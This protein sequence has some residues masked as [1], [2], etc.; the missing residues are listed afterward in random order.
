MKIMVESEY[1]KAE[2]N[3][4]LLLTQR[5]IQVCRLKCPTG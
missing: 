4:K 2:N 5:I 3:E 1:G